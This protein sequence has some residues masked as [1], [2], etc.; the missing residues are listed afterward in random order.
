MQKYQESYRSTTQLNF[1]LKKKI[2]IEKILPCVPGHG[3]KKCFENKP[4]SCYVCL[5][6]ISHGRDMPMNSTSAIG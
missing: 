3:L 6:K 4:A 5:N 2:A 1:F